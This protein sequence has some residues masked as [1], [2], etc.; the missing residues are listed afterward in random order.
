[1]SKIFHSLITPNISFNSSW[2]YSQVMYWGWRERM[3]APTTARFKFPNGAVHGTI[4][5]R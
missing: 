4:D 2:L 5:E 1:M 3:I